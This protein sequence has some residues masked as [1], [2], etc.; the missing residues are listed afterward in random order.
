MDKLTEDLTWILTDFKHEQANFAQTVDKIQEL[1]ARQLGAISLQHHLAVV[2][3]LE[4]A[5]KAEAPPAF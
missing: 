4:S 3:K 5:L 2:E 1:Y